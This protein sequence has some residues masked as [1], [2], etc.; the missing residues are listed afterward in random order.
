MDRQPEY[1]DNG[2]VFSIAAHSLGSVIIYDILSLH[3][4]GGCGYS[5]LLFSYMSLQQMSVMHH[6]RMKDGISYYK[7]FKKLKLG[8]QVLVNVLLEYL[9]AHTAVCNQHYNWNRIY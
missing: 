8:R 5:L 3:K 4:T 9:S 2:G 1:I 7:N 6:L